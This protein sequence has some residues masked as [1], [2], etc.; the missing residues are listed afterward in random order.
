MFRIELDI[1]IHAVQRRGEELRAE[2][3]QVGAD[4]AARNGQSIESIEVDVRSNRDDD[5]REPS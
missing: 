4:L 2:L 5:P 3:E 1:L